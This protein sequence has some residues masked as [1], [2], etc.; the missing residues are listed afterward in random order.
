V[1]EAMFSA[2]KEILSPERSQKIAGLLP[3]QIRH[4]WEHA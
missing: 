3:E 1:T 4:L 2:T